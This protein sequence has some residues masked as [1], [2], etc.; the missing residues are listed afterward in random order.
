MF[1]MTQE[2]VLKIFKENNALLNGHFKLSSGLHSGQY[3]QCALLLQYPDIAEKLCRELAEK[4]ENEKI[5]VVIGP[6][7]G[8]ITVSY[9]VARA[10]G[11][12]SLFAERDSTNAMVLRRGF[13]IDR[14]DRVLL[15]EDVITT[16]GSVGE[17]VNIV[18]TNGA[19]LV[20]IG[21]LIDR[22]NGKASFGVPFKALAKVEVIT[23]EEKNCPFCKKGLPAVKPG[24]K[25]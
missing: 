1:K 7:L 13:S 17:L 15:V 5:T 19:E 11:V 25:F 20:G 22:S 9:E 10:L 3:L 23:Y 4:F 6:A 12:R 21:S 16:G 2:E 18:K 24:S 14:S 8:G